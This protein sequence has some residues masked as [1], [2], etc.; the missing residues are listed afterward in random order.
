[1]EIVGNLFTVAY[2]VW[3]ASSTKILY[4]H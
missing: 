3:A 1:M 4:V 2:W